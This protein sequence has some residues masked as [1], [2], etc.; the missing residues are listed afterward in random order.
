MV[1]IALM[2]A[3][4]VIALSPPRAAPGQP[5]VTL[6]RDLPIGA[7]LAADDVQ[8]DQAESLDR[9]VGTALLTDDVQQVL[10]GRPH[11]PQRPT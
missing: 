9:V 1:A 5:V 8:I 10:G 6:T 4:G 3:A 11:A 2:L 7:R